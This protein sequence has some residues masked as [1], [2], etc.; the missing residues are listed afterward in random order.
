MTQTVR[1]FADCTTITV[2]LGGSPHV[3]F[4]NIP[5]WSKLNDESDATFASGNFTSSGDSVS[6]CLKLP[7]PTLEL[8]SAAAA[9]D[10]SVTIRARWVGAAG[11]V[12]IGML[13]QE[14]FQRIAVANYVDFT[15][16]SPNL[17][18]SFQDIVFAGNAFFGNWGTDVSLIDLSDITLTFQMVI[19]SGL[20]KTLEISRV[21]VTLPVG[22]NGV[23]LVA[24]N[25]SVQEPNQPSKTFTPTGPLVITVTEGASGT[26]VLVQDQSSVTITTIDPLVA[27]LSDQA[28][29]VDIPALI[30]TTERAIVKPIGAD[31]DVVDAVSA[32][33]ASTLLTCA[34]DPA[35]AMYT[36]PVDP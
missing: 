12:S 27:S 4:D 10:Y 14:G 31:A 19:S 7:P 28:L 1:P 36:C 22:V 9:S 13:L 2:E 29:V 18:T 32:L 23:I 8:D 21:E 34:N 17:T 16:T 20:P 5:W 11:S 26:A 15:P 25:A 33:L 24:D 35:P 3:D 30:A 6:M